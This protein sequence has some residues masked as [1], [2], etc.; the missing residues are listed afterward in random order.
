MLRKSSRQ[1]LLAV[2]GGGSGN[3]V[4]LSID[5]GSASACS[6]SGSAVMF[7]NPGSCVIDANQADNTR[8]Q[9]APQAQQTIT[10][11]PIQ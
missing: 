5:A 9:P 4:I 8:Y 1:H 7:N 3:P 10:V 11:N 2:S 6:I